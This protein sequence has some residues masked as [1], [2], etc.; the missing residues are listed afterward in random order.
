[1]SAVIQ[2]NVFVVLRCGRTNKTR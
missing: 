2:Q 1:M